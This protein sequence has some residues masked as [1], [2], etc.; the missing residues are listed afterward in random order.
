MAHGE[1]WGI[2]TIVCDCCEMVNLQITKEH[3]G[4][5]PPDLNYIAGSLSHTPPL[6]GSFRGIVNQPHLAQRN[7]MALVVLI[8]MAISYI[9]HNVWIVRCFT[10]WGRVTHMCVSKLTII[11][12]DNGLSPG[13]CQAIIWTNAGILLIKPCGT[14]FNE[15]WIKI[16]QFSFKKMRLKMSSGKRRPFCLSLNVLMAV[17]WYSYCVMR[18]LW[19][20]LMALAG[21]WHQTIHFITRGILVC[22]NE[23]MKIILQIMWFTNSG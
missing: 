7:T 15:I 10:H 14:N 16:K 11:G 19:W 12:S 13:R 3:I 9:C 6:S 5:W 23:S 4:C 21:I 22:Q 18:F 2:Y 20:F 8:G 1:P 17:K